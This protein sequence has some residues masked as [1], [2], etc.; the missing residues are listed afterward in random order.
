[1][2]VC[3]GAAAKG[4]RQTAESKKGRKRNLGKGVARPSWESQERAA[5]EWRWGVVARPGELED[6]AP[7]VTFSQKTRTELQ[8]TPIQPHMAKD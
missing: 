8:S 1:M 7:R 4:S 2:H 6:L 3:S 5:V